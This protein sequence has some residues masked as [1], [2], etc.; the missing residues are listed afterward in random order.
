MGR[1]CIKRA[2]YLVLIIAGLVVGGCQSQ[3]PPV[4]AMRGEEMQQQYTATAAATPTVIPTSIPSATATAIPTATPIADASGYDADALG[5][6]ALIN[7]WR[8]EEGLA[9]FSPHD[10]LFAMAADRRITYSRCRR[11]LMA[12]RS[13]QARTANHRR[14]AG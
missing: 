7:R 3:T 6:I 10:T 9:P 1:K 8:I 14:S 4:Q 5:M 2:G 12:R 11:F 13:T